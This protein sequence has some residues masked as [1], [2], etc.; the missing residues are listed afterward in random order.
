M[1]IPFV[2]LKGNKLD[3]H[4]SIKSLLEFH[5]VK[6]KNMLQII[7]V[8]ATVIGAIVVLVWLW[9]LSDKWKE[10]ILEKIYGEKS[11]K[12]LDVDNLLRFIMVMVGMVLIWTPIVLLMS[13]INTTTFNPEEKNK[14]ISTK[15]FR[16]FLIDQNENIDIKIS[17]KFES[18]SSDNKY[19]NHYFN[20][21]TVLPED[22]QVDRGNFTHTIIRCFKEDQGVVISINVTPLTNISNQREIEQIHESFQESP[23]F[24]LDEK[25]NGNFKS[26]Y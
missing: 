1:E 3:H 20:F 12:N 19:S 2:I 8:A 16:E 22:F 26:H 15:S 24:Y 11:T 18:L 25:F 4:S 21:S 6:Q 5:D 7:L 10:I 23:L 13:F 17:N 14:T 9:K